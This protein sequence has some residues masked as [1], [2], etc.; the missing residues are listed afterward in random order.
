MNNST[1]SNNHLNSID[2]QLFR[3]I[4]QK[5]VMTTTTIA[6]LPA[7]FFQLCHGT[8][9][10]K[11]KPKYRYVEQ[12]NQ[13]DG[14]WQGLPALAPNW[15][16]SDGTHF[17]TETKKHANCKEHHLQMLEPHSFLQLE[18]T[19]FRI[20]ASIN[21]LMYRPYILELIW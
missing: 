11:C 15:T 20:L 3:T 2:Q 7:V 8:Q 5:L 13:L 4:D 17:Y 18:S 12:G 19:L 6:D 14:E 10:Y 16:H 9:T 21:W 1:G